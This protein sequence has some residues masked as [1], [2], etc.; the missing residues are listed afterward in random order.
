MITFIVLKKTYLIN[1]LILLLSLICIYMYVTIYLNKKSVVTF[2]PNGESYIVLIIDDFGADSDG[3]TAFKNL[4]VP[5]TAAIMP[6]LKYS[7]VESEFFSKSKNDVIM[8]LPM[9]AK[10]GN[11]SWLGPNP[12]TVNLSDSKIREI[13]IDGL[14]K[15]HGV[16]GINNHMGSKAMESERVLKI[17]FQVAKEKGLIIVDSKTT[18][19]SLPKKMANQYGVKVYERDVFLDSET[20]EYESIKKNLDKAVLIAKKNGYAIAIGHV[21]GAGGSVTAKAISEKYLEIES[22]NI[23]F[24]TITELNK[25][26]N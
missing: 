18:P 23:K 19:L 5:F 12:I 4:P 13:V 8:H 20:K 26:L 6:Y 17:V 15:L 25:L 14:E 10:S 21:G 2:G 22:Q 16:I 1:L 11:V 7:E 3:T 24:I 9:E